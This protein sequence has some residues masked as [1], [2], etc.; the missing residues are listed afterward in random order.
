MAILDNSAKKRWR[1]HIVRRRKNAV[2]LG[3]AADYQIERLILR[4][5]SRLVSVRRFI[6]LWISL[7]V[8]MIF[9]GVVQIR[10]L[11]PYYQ[12]LQPVPGGIYSEGLIG[13]FKNANPLYASGAADIAVSRL[14][15]SGLFKFDKD[16]NFVPDLASDIQ[17]GPTATHYTVTL[18]QGLTWHDG[19]DFTAD[20]V[21]FTYKT[22]QNIESQSTLY[23]NWKDI[24]V[25]K[26]G[27]Y[28]IT[29]DLPNPLTAFPHSLINGII[30]AH[31][32]GDVASVK[33]R[34]HPFNAEPVGT[35]PF[36]WRF[37]EVINGPNASR[38]QRITLAAFD[39]YWSGRPKLD[40]FNLLTFADEQQL[41]NSFKKK[42]LNA[43]SRLE[44]VPE[45]LA[46]DQSVQIYNIPLTNAVMAF[47]KNS[48]PILADPYVRRAL[49]EAVDRK[50]LLN[51]TGYPT[52]LAESP[53]LHSHLGY[54]RDLLQLPYDPAAASQM[55]DQAGWVR[56][57]SGIRSKNDQNLVLNLRSQNTRQYTLV[58]QYLQNQWE[59][60]GVK[61]NVQYYEADDLQSQAIATHD[62]DILVYSISL[63]VD[64]DV[65]AY[66][67]SS[68]AS[69]NSLG[70]LNLSEYKQGAADQALEA[71]RTRSDPAIRI[72]KYRAFLQQ[73]RDDAP[74]LALYQPNYLYI[75][76][77]TVYG[78][79]RQAVN[80]ASD[81]FFNVE[82]WMIRQKRLNIN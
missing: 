76:R 73:W 42:Q 21:V 77:G 54:S 58:S 62:Y 38:E 53:L 67:D 23:S 7:F 56:D 28:V 34:S 63:G 70:H 74:A 19:H 75:S 12:S 66:W 32:L 13:S 6:F 17:L 68:Q 80:A 47:F 49:V 25:K 2:D 64:P 79:E 8:L 55:L 1:R 50:P 30:P 9:C 33:L 16:N 29:F 69:I 40:G 27:D 60:I 65:Y 3:I 57:A 48:N 61:V 46:K 37:I 14:V 81:R 26:L 36:K 43:M 45:D 82:N 51:I 39:N 18:R 44:S 78:F 11:S 72:V 5:L 22:I 52:H 41:L 20:D 15:F 24:V 59:K 10:A 35:G 71:G 31:L 4:R